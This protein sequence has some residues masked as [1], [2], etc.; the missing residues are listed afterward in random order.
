MALTLAADH[1][2]YSMAWSGPAW[3]AVCQATVDGALRRL[4]FA[5]PPTS[6]KWVVWHEA[7]V[8]VAAAP[9]AGR[10]AVFTPP[11]RL[12]AGR[13]YAVTYAHTMPHQRSER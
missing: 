13:P 8:P 12:Q 2:L 6:A 9:L 4:R 7:G 10:E 5:P 11:V 1:T 3:T